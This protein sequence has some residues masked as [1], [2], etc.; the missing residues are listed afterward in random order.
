MSSNPLRLKYLFE[1]YLH[2]TCSKQELEE[3]WQLMS[4]LSDTD[5]IHSGLRELWHQDAQPD[6]G[7]KPNWDHVYGRLQQ[8]AAQQ[9]MDYTKLIFT[10]R[11]RMVQMAVAAAVIGGR[12]W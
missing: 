2:N 3:F 7:E 10:R 11:R 1:K 6:M 8:K 9:Q 5:L 4:E 12:G